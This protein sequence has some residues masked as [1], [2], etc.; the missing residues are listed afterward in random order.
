MV[1]LIKVADGKWD[2]QAGD[3]IVGTCNLSNDYH[4]SYKAEL[5]NGIVINAFNQKA[6]KEMISK[7]I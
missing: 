4:G 6:L 7:K 2:V 3:K 5:N 1:K